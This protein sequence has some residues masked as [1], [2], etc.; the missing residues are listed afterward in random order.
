MSKRGV[1]SAFLE[2]I[3]KETGGQNRTN[4]IFIK[5]SFFYLPD[6]PMLMIGP[7][8]GVAPFIAFS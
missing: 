8:T 5:D 6:A 3:F 7:G 4:R 2:D 1:T